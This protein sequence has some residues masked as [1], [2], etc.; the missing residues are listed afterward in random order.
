M[1]NEKESRS[2]EL[3]LTLVDIA[4]MDV[5]ELVGRDKMGDLDFAELE[6]TFQD[7]IDTAKRLLELEFSELESRD[8]SHFE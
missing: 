4:R 1:S 5:A 2:Q 6:T 8:F 7:I 3:H